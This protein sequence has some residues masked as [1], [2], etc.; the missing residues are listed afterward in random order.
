MRKTTLSRSLFLTAALTLG[1]STAA[2]AQES[3]VL[4]Y[5]EAAPIT[6]IEGLVNGDYVL[7][8]HNN[9]GASG[10]TNPTA[11]G[12]V[13]YDA[14]SSD[15]QRR[16]KADYNFDFQGGVITDERYVWT[17]T[18]NDDHTAFSLQNKE[19]VYLC[20]TTHQQ[21]Y[22]RGDMVSSDD[23]ANIAWYAPE[24]SDE[25]NRFFL[26][27]DGR[28]VAEGAPNNTAGQPLYLMTNNA[29]S[30]KNLSYWNSTSPA[31]NGGAVRMQFLPV[32]SRNAV[33]ITYNYL[34]NGQVVG[35]ETLHAYVGSEFPSPTTL[36]AFVTGKIPEGTVTAGTTEYSVD[37][38][39]DGPFAISESVQNATWYAVGLHTAPYY[40]HNT[41]GAE[42]MTL[43][44]EQQTIDA[45]TIEAFD[46]QMWCF[47][48]NP[49][50]GFKIYN[51]AA[52]A[53]KILSSS[54]TMSGNN[55]GSTYP[56][57][58]D[59]ATLPDGNNMTW[60]VT[61]STNISGVNGFYIAQ[62]GLASN[63]MNLRDGRLAYWSIN[64]DH[65]STFRVLN[66]QALY[67]A[68]LGTYVSVSQSHPGYVGALKSEII[69][70]YQSTIDAL[71][72]GTSSPEA[73]VTLYNAFNKPENTIALTDG[74]YYRLHC[75]PV[76][77]NFVLSANAANMGL[78]GAAPSTSDASQ[79]WKAVR[80]E[81]GKYKLITQGYAIGGGNS[82][83]LVD[84]AE[85]VTFYFGKNLTRDSQ[86]DSHIIW[87]FDTTTSESN[88]TSKSA[89]NLVSQ[90]NITLFPNNYGASAWMVE[91]VKTL[92]V[93]MN[94]VGNETWATLYLPFSV[95]TPEG[96]TAYTGTQK[97]ENTVQLTAIEGGVIPA[98]TGV[99]L[100]GTATTC[101]LT[102]TN[103][104]VAPVEGNI[105]TGT[106]L[107][108]SVTQETLENYYV[109]STLQGVIG[110]YWPQE[111][112]TALAANKA[113]ID[114]TPAAGA[115][116]YRF[117]FGDDTTVGIDG[118][119]LGQPSDAPY[120]DLSGRRVAQPAKGIYIHN[121][122]KVFI[123]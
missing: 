56:I 30:Y 49:F 100:K 74:G 93:T 109:L 82:L 77:G 67:N 8:L 52:G 28:V 9:S 103:D 65:G 91:E 95:T 69:E 34:Y 41:D 68:E 46:A 94:T 76:R 53:G 31:Q 35:S 115:A 122:K 111:G 32:S 21:N 27:L 108:I 66:L 4:Y 92:D 17:L 79:I 23:E 123:K 40:L 120:Y 83:S 36:P 42:S 51:K 117:V 78:R 45:S 101:P 89:L 119:Q 72:A 22:G 121:G 10:A 96:V 43:A 102:L 61:P 90:D 13:Y 81:D 87:F 16:Y 75:A 7:D 86:G 1:G 104:A 25:E 55:G 26:R 54:T 110:L 107:P 14:S 88:N 20:V 18:W 24:A 64:A 71:T 29:N 105:F 3:Q 37:C 73:Y 113:Y 84:E 19:G 58:V 5:D 80:T 63:R 44:A 60:D 2:Q 70:Q 12:L 48:G 47:V 118:A 6:S 97:D 38:T 106:C 99:V 116:G 98:Q 33:P 39:W 11:T 62:H 50:D 15:A 59:E 57:L 114:N 85:A 112:T